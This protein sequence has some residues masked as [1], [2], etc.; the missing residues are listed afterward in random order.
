MVR[1]KHC[2]VSERLIHTNF[3]F[4]YGTIKTQWGKLLVLSGDSFQFHYG[5][6]KTNFSIIT[7]FD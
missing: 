6:I 4:H 2:V 5:T 3:Q 1:L 7:T